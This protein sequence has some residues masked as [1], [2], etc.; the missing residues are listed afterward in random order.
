[1]PTIAEIDDGLRAFQD[2]SNQCFSSHAQSGRDVR[3]T[4]RVM[5]IIDI[6]ASGQIGS[7]VFE[8]PLAPE[9]QRCVELQLAKVKFAESRDG[10]TIE[11]TLEFSR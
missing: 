4:V 11:R 7:V 3:V 10:V 5:A 6:A 8:P 1:V 9:V 2:A